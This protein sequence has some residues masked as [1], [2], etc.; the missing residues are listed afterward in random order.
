MATLGVV[1]PLRREGRGPESR[2][3]RGVALVALVVFVIAIMAP[4]FEFANLFDI[5]PTGTAGMNGFIPFGYA[6]VLGELIILQ[7]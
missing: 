2:S 4:K 5:E 3:R 1:Q 6:G 7:I